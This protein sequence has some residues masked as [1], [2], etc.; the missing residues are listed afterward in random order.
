M[1]GE[2]WEPAEGRLVDTRYG[3]KH[4]DRSGNASVTVNSVHY[5]MEVQPLS[6]GEPFR[7]ECTPPSMMLSFK[8]PPLNVTVK[9]ECIPSKKKAR[10]DRDDPAISKKVSGERDRANY[11]AELHTRGSKPRQ[12]AG[13]A[14]TDRSTSTT[15][16]ERASTPDPVEQLSRLAELHASGVLSDDQFEAMRDKIVAGDA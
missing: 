7:C 14:K 1:F 10:F 9:M 13:S 8:S 16:F 3:G 12:D 11:E 6:G 5:L 4:G 2:K 15:A